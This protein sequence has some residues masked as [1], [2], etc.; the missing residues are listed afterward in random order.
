[1]NT[2]TSFL[3]ITTTLPLMVTTLPQPWGPLQ[4]NRDG[5][6]AFQRDFSELERSINSRILEENQEGIQ[7][8][9]NSFDNA[10]YYAGA[11]RTDYSRNIPGFVYDEPDSVF[12]SHQYKNDGE[13]YAFTIIE[14]KSNSFPPSRTF[15]YFS[16]SSPQGSL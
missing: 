1:M 14:N 16:S 15:T 13:S 5:I 7:K 10:A 4:E 6:S 8:F 9:H 11:L 3:V 12:T 2:L